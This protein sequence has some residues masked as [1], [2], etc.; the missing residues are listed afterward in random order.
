MKPMQYI[1]LLIILLDIIYL[2]TMM[3]FLRHDEIYMNVLG[4]F[5]MGAL[6]TL[7]YFVFQNKR[8]HASNYRKLHY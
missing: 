1:K 5:N 4:G 7:T 8:K 3:W 6:S 2:I